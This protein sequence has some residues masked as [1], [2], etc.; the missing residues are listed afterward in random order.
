[1]NIIN[2]V[3]TVSLSSPLDLDE[4]QKALPGSER[5]KGGARWLKYR[6]GAKKRYVAFY[7]SGKF[8]IDGC[9]DGKRYPG[10]FHPGDRTAAEQRDRGQCEGDDGPEYSCEG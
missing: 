2:M 8:L 9:Q 3:A 10:Y 6:L 1:M 5:C 7:S 4:V